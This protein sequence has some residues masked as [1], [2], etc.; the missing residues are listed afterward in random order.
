MKDEHVEAINI[1]KMGKE[2][3][4]SYTGEYDVVIGHLQMMEVRDNGT[5]R[6]ASTCRVETIVSND[7]AN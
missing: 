4:F 6:K 5:N 2:I 3:R 7:E 1:W